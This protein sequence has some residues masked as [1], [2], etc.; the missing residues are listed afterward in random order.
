MRRVDA[1]GLVGVAIAV[2]IVVLSLICAY[3]LYVAP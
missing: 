3:I 1:V 2:I